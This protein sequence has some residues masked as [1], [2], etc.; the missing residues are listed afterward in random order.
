MKVLSLAVARARLCKEK[1]F[2]N[3]AC[4]ES[5]KKTRAEVSQESDYIA[6]VPVL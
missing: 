6:S 4:G 1:Q 2:V 3:G 5:E